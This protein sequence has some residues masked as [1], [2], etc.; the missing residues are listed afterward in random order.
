MVAPSG[1]WS[2]PSPS[3]TKWM[4]ASMCVP[5]CEPSDISETLEP[6]PRPMSSIRSMRTGGLSGQWTIPLLSGMETSIQPFSSDARVSAA[7]TEILLSTT[8]P[9]YNK[10]NMP[11]PQDKPRRLGYANFRSLKP[12]GAFQASVKQRRDQ[13]YQHQQQRIA[14]LPGQLRHVGKVHTVDAGE[15]GRDREDGRPGADLLDL[16]VLFY[17]RL[18]EVLDLLVLVHAHQRE[19]HHDDTREQLVE[20]LDL[21]RRP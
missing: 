3:H 8:S 17:A 19:V 20:G 18:R 16:I 21:L 2:I 12:P 6:S 13:H 5:V 15:D 7:H 14:G 11:A 10:I 4:G 1:I 9:L